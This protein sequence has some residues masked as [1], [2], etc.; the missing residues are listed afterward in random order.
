MTIENM[1][2]IIEKI[3]YVLERIDVP[4]KK[5]LDILYDTEGM[6]DKALRKK[7]DDI[8]SAKIV[9]ISE[10]TDMRIIENIIA[11]TNKLIDSVND[12]N[13]FLSIINSMLHMHFNRLF[14]DNK[15]ER[16]YRTFLYRFLKRKEFKKND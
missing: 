8:S 10:D 14:G 5:I 13:Y 6:K 7:Y 12:E 16:E 9:S 1:K 11:N 15:I 3:I 4:N 2:N